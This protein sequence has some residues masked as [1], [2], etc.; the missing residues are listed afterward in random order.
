M[1]KDPVTYPV[2]EAICYTLWH[3]CITKQH[4]PDVALML[5]QALHSYTSHQIERHVKKEKET[6]VD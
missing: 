4:S 1:N 3:K 2:T 5:G 6:L